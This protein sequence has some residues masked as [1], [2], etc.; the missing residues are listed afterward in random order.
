M[1]VKMNH[2]DKK[3]VAFDYHRKSSYPFH[4][5]PPIFFS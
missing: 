1:Y 5:S 3:K 2:T 4:R